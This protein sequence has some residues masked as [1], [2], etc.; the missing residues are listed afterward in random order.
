MKEGPR[1][2]QLREQREARFRANHSGGSR[3]EG[4]PRPHGESLQQGAATSSKPSTAAK[5]RGKGSDAANVAKPQIEP[6]SAPPQSPPETKLKLGRPK[7][8]ETREKP[9]ETE[10]I[11]KA[12]WYRRRKEQGK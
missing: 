10:G 1:E 4:N 11:S 12:G 9:W 7:K 6:A 2:Q 3:V 8:G 5:P